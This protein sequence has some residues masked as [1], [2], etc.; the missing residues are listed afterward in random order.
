LEQG[1]SKIESRTP[2]GSVG[3]LFKFTNGARSEAMPS[4]HHFLKFK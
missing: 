3:V 1:G 4:W 2:K